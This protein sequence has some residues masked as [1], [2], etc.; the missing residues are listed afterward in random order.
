MVFTKK[1]PFFTK[2]SNQ[3]GKEGFSHLRSSL[4]SG[5]LTEFYTAHAYFIA[6]QG[7]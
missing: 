6:T 3:E 1:N 5:I 7:Y 2:K 4:A